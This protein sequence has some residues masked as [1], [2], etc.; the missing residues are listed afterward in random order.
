M[1]YLTTTKKRR[2]RACKSFHL[3]CLR[4]FLRTALQQI[5]TN[6]KTTLSQ[7]RLRWLALVIRMGEEQ[8][9]KSLLYGEL[10]VGKHNRSR[11]KRRFKDVCKRDLKSLNIRS[12]ELELLANDRTKWRSI[13]HKRLEEMEKE[14]FKKTKK[15]KK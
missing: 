9:P 4:R 15:M 2:C 12:D 14:Y 5:I 8:V 6:K 1:F 13:V 3:R 7:H 10:V 11:P